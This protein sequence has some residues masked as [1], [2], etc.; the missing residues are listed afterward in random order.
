MPLD[1]S[2]VIVSYN[3]RDYLR[4]CLASIEAQ[5]GDLGVEVG[6][7]RL[8]GTYVGAGESRVER[9]QNLALRHALALF[10]IEGLDDRLI[11]RLQHDGRVHGDDLTA[12]RADDPIDPHRQVGAHP[13]LPPIHQYLL[14][15][16]HVVK[17]VG[18]GGAAPKV[19]HGLQIKAFDPRYLDV[20]DER[21]MLLHCDMP[22]AEPV[23]HEELGARD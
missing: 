15:P 22:V 9:R 7:L 18:W 12:D 21:G 20:C 19:A 4:H 8:Q 17:N 2:I 1:L 6:D 16:M 23:A 13:Y 14:P 10:Y 11:E 5:K 3:T